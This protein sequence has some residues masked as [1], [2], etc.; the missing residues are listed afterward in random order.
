MWTVL[1]SKENK[2]VTLVATKMVERKG[3]VARKKLSRAFKMFVS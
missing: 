3:H 1:Q 2:I